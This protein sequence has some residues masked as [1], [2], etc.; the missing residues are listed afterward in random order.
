MMYEMIRWIISIHMDD[1]RMIRW[2][3]SIHMDVKYG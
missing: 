1:E 2:I 3:I